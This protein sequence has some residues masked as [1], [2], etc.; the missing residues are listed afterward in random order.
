MK[1]INSNSIN[2]K[3]PC[4]N[5]YD[6]DYDWTISDAEEQTIKKEWRI[7]EKEIGFDFNIDLKDMFFGE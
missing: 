3:S 4:I 6:Y 1:V 7:L 5:F 2:R